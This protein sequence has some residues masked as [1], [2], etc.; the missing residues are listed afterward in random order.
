M[1]NLQFSDNLWVTYYDDDTEEKGFYI[2][3]VY[4]GTDTTRT[5]IADWLSVS[6]VKFIEQAILRDIDIRKTWGD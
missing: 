2:N 6:A 4:V 3:E 1:A 5:N